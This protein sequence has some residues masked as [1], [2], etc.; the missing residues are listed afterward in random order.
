MFR[1]EFA[2]L[3]GR[4]LALVLAALQASVYA[5]EPMKLTFAGSE[6][7]HRWSKNGQNEF[8]PPSEPDLAKWQHMVT[9]NVHEKVNDG[10]QLAALANSV[11]S[12]YQR[13]GKILRTDSKPRMK[14]QPAE[15]LIVAI[16]GAPGLMEAVFAR[17]RLVDGVGVIVVYSQREYGEKAAATI[18]GWLQ[19]N[20]QATEKSL[21]TWDKLPALTA[22]KQLPQSK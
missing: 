8:T 22:L 19:T 17:V 6:Y 10:D 20:G 12:N 9:I 16:L 21:M 14:D 5:A 3:I 18:G 1:S 7:V 11:L 15:H 2:A 4:A 13:A